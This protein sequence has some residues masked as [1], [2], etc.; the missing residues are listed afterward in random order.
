MTT[1]ITLEESWLHRMSF[2]AKHGNIHNFTGCSHRH[3][4]TALVSNNNVLSY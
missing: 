1:I 2:G 4:D 3:T